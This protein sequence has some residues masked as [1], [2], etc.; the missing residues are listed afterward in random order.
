[1]SVK[2][3]ISARYRARVLSGLGFVPARRYLELRL[4]MREA[5][6]PE[7]EH[8]SLQCRHLRP[9]EEDKLTHIQ[10]RAF[11]DTWG[12]NPNTVE[13]T[14]YCLNMSHRSPEDVVLVCEGDSIVGYCWTEIACGKDEREGRIYMLGVDPDCRRVGMGRRLLLA[15]LARLRSKGISVAVLTV[16][17]ENEVACALYQSVGFE[18]RAN[19]M[20]YEKA[21]IR[22]SEVL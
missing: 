11:T 10:N 21:V 13:S 2:S 19:S 1:M 3:D 9:G 12:Y 18:V 22:D 7:N 16:D 17:R 4:D 6:L 14:R 5:C 20:W 8:N 15:G